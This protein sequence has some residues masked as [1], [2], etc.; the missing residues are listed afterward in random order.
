M[1]RRNF[2]KYTALLPFAGLLKFSQSDNQVEKTVKLIKKYFEKEL[3]ALGKPDVIKYGCDY[4]TRTDKHIQMSWGNCHKRF[5]VD[6]SVQKFGLA[7]CY[8]EQ[9]IYID[10]KIVSDV[11]IESGLHKSHQPQKPY[12]YFIA[13]PA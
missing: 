3:S 6:D 7:C 4:K 9:D 8:V 1:L 13:T 5:W 10:K 11:V 12:I 2:L